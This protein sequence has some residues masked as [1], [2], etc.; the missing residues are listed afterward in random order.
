MSRQSYQLDPHQKVDS[1]AYGDSNS[2]NN[3]LTDKNQDPSKNT[4]SRSSD[5]TFHTGSL[6]FDSSPFPSTP[7]DK[8]ALIQGPVIT[9]LPFAASSSP[10]KLDRVSAIISGSF[11]SNS[12][13]SNISRRPSLF[14][15]DSISASN[16]SSDFG[17][18]RI[19]HSEASK[20]ST[21]V[22]TGTNTSVNTSSTA[23]AVAA[24]LKRSNLT[25]FSKTSTN[26]ISSY[27]KNSKQ[28]DSQPC[29][30]LNTDTLHHRNNN[31]L[32]K[33]LDNSIPT[34]WTI[35]SW[36][37]TCCFPRVLLTFVGVN[38]KNQQ[39]AWREKVA[40]CWISVILSTLVVI[41]LI[42][43]NR[44]FCP[45]NILD[46]T[47]DI[48]AFG[49]VV[50]FGRMYNSYYTTPPYNTLFDQTDAFGG[51]DVSGSFEQPQISACQLLNVAEHKFASVQS[52]CR[53]DCIDLN[54]LTSQHNFLPYSTVTNF[55]GQNVTVLPDPA[56]PWSEVKRRNLVVFRQ[57]VLN[58]APYFDAH[59][60]PI[61][62]DVMDA[63]LRK[64]QLTNDATRI[65]WKNADI[66]PDMANCLVQKYYAG[67]LS[68]LPM[69]CILS[70]LVTIVVS[71]TVSS[72]LLTRFAMA[73]FFDRVL[74]S[75]LIRTCKNAP[76]NPYDPVVAKK[77]EN[78]RGAKLHS[79]IHLSLNSSTDQR[80]MLSPQPQIGTI[81][82][83]QD[84]TIH[85]PAPNPSDLYTVMFVTCYSEGESALRTTLDSLALTDYDDC[86]KILFVVA[87]GIVKGSD[88][89]IST[90]DILIS[91]M[92]HDEAFGN[93]PE[94][95]SYVSIATGTKQHNMA[96]VY[97]GSYSV[98]GRHIPMVL[99]IKCGTEYEA[100]Q[101]KP[102]N[103]GKRDSQMILMNFFSRI[104]LYDR[105]TPLDYDI[106]RKI[107]YLTGV[108]P[109]VYELVLM[110][111]ADTR[112]A[113]D[114]LRFMVNAMHNEPRIMGLCGETRIANKKDS[115]VT[116]IQVFE[117]FISHHLGKAFESVF[118]GVTCLPGCFCMY[119]LKTVKDGSVL[120]VL[121][122]P[123]II[124]QYA[125]NE[126]FT[127]HQKNLLL[128]GEDRF[129]ST[130]M[131]RTFP[132]RLMMFVPAAYCKT[133][134]PDK[135]SV[136]LSQ[137]RRW[138]NS[139][140]HNLMELVFVNNLCGTFCF[141]MQF[142]VFMD[143]LGTAVLP[144]SLVCTYYL[145]IYAIVYPMPYNITSFLNLFVMIITIFLPMLLV[146]LSGR[147][148]HYVL[149][150][151]VYLFTLP[152]WQIV[153]PL[154]SFWYF[155]DFSWGETRK[156]TGDGH[157]VSNAGA[158]HDDEQL[159]GLFDGSRIPFRRWDE[160]EREARFEQRKHILSMTEPHSQPTQT[161]S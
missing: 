95:F 128:L 146:L 30:G 138:I 158:Q 84:P 62:G 72:I 59:P 93:S 34:L 14:R 127:L 154:Y 111:D 21:S 98:H 101:S 85:R 94:A 76:E 125:T 69:T 97:C 105:M 107:H 106:F 144:A 10:H 8:D 48:N 19:H 26:D 104:V 113:P 153:F 66:T 100:G 49:G 161:Q 139:T 157:E 29:H 73:V 82:R 152:I 64:A 108:T 143:L 136:L 23:Q 70:R 32:A 86:K 47:V 129:L 6:G 54:V 117:Y 89:Q 119:R 123:D 155:D 122:N 20:S 149:W 121:V 74:A 65:L 35:F 11:N 31:M 145:I 115:W 68:Q 116:M 112:V 134:V 131:L 55:F 13:G 61:S 9:E 160:Y 37:L 12:N 103:R 58:L 102:G 18:H 148:V 79:S 110:V 92:H 46:N 44:L 124:E 91:M 57:V 53:P 78:S 133:T 27:D 109:D 75:R 41:F 56:Y 151:F 42:F 126:A 90:P 45:D 51:I 60:E 88:N 63:L 135:F 132:K 142:V 80:E 24:L 36:A 38:T 22:D 77:S 140:V 99:I 25:P 2:I 96:R 71:I 52:T 130:L 17:Q 87:D 5:S 15:R 83:R 67:V 120:P 4:P 16:I 159:H 1:T 150:M 156:V 28:I 3:P 118:G 50:V 33:P 137:R 39:Q 7:N 81:M 147:R 40:L 114:S 43:F 141:S